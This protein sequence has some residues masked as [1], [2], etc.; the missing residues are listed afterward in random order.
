[1]LTS[2]GRPA[3]RLAVAAL[4]ACAGPLAAACGSAAGPSPAPTATITVTSPTPGSPAAPASAPGSTAASSPAGPAG[5]A[6]SALQ[7]SVGQGGGAAGSTYYPVEF[8]N[9]SG[10]TCTLYGYPGVSFV[11]KVGGQ[12]IGRAARQDTTL[13]RR[14]VT[15]APGATAHAL[16]QVVNA[17]NFPAAQCG[18]VT[19]HW[20]RVYPPGQFGA[21]YIRF[22]APA[23]SSTAKAVRILGIQT[24]QPGQ[25]SQ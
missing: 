3:R 18:L 8:T 14:L 9:V 22:A 23:C 21:L 25:G 10:T 5:C 13:A 1:M 15:L 6:T 12:R 19:A 24:V 2:S 16:L 20:L 4:L 17:M 11:T 7:A